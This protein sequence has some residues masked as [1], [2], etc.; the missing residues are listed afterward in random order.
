[1]Q[2]VVDG[3]PIS[4]ATCR[5]AQSIESEKYA[6][7]LEWFRRMR[8]YFEERLDP[9]KPAVWLGDLTSLPSRSM[10]TTPIAA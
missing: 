5:R 2:T 6:F 3:I 8:E 1:M 9:A 10:S 4:T 7:K